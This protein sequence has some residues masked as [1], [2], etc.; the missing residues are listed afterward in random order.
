MS[1]FGGAIKELAK[2]CL[3]FRGLKVLLEVKN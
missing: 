1:D 2:Y 3:R